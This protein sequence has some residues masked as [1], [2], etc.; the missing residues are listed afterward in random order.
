MLNTDATYKALDLK[1]R[2]LAQKL[3]DLRKAKGPAG[4]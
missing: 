1:V 2:T 4:K 3:T